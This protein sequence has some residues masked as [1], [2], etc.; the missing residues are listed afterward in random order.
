MELTT[1]QQEIKREFIDVRGTWSESWEA[2]LVL[3]PEFLAGYLTMSSVPWKK[4]K[5]EDKVKEFIYIAVDSAATHMYLPGVRQ[6][7]RAALRLGATSA[8]IMEVVELAS[9]LG[10]HAMNVGIPILCEV[11]DE[12]GLR[13]EEAPLSEYQEK[14]KQEFTQNRGYWS[15]T[16]DDT[17]SLDPEYLEA[18]T[19]FSS[20]SWKYGPLEPKVK[21]FIYI[22]FD[23]AATHLY[24]RGTKLHMENALRY[25]ATIEEIVEVLEIASVIGIHAATTA[26]P[27]IL[28]EIAAFEAEEAA[29]R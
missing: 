15:K 16:W 1:R 12:A 26:A 19:E 10:V 11:L 6:H 29:T 24:E 25:G 9:T 7:V 27:I 18:Y 2:I 20:A 28:E 22:A 17:L 21:E 14:V 13:T 8:E 23:I 5:L 3:S 4:N